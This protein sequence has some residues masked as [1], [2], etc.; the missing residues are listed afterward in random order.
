MSD[1]AAAT[2]TNGAAAAA[3]TPGAAPAAGAGA[4]A[5]AAGAGT[6]NEF[7]SSLPEEIRADPSLQSI[8]DLPSL[9]KGYVH[10]QK[11]VGADKVVVPKEGADPKEWDAF[12]N[13]VGRPEKPE[14]YKFTDVKM[15]EGFGVDTKLQERFAGTFHK[16]GLSQKQ[17]DSIR[18]EFVQY[19]I[20]TIQGEI[21]AQNQA[22]EAG[23][24]ALRE[25]WGAD[26]DVNVKKAEKAL[27]KFS[28]PALLEKLKKTGLGSDPD[29]VAAF[30]DIGGRMTEDNAT[31]QGGQDTGATGGQAEV[32]RLMKDEEFQKSLHDRWHKDHKENVKKWTEA[33]Q[34]AV[35]TK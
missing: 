15:P 12:F 22:V 20:E 27:A 3:G 8:K 33:H 26:Y 25:K 2:V 16:H 23:E 5:P 28:S 24:K 19:Q 35:A 13:K 1:G 18:S 29:I 31:G 4:A 7:L 9:A 34:R 17:A 6:T 11:L 21:K 10:A 30:A 32:D 14:G